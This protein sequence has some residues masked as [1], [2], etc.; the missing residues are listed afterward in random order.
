MAAPVLAALPGAI[1]LV[2]RLTLPQVAALLSR[3]A[4]FIGNDSG[5]MH[6]AA[7][8]GAPTLGL[9]GPTPADEYGPCGPRARVVLA[10]QHD[11]PPGADDLTRF[12]FMENL[13]VERALAAAKE[14]L[15]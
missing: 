1:D 10:D 5:L 14:L 15:A 9:F 12:P 8:A 2:G 6:L 7:A 13:P 4:L 11:Y 3:A